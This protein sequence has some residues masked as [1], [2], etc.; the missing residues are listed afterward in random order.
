MN[1]KLRQSARGRECTLRFPGICSHDPETTVLCHV[2]T[3]GIARK[4]PDTAAVF[5]CAC[6]HDLIDRRDARWAEF[7]PGEIAAQV[8]RALVE[9]H[10]IWKREGLIDA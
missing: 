1:P 2:A 7:G 9:T 8:L 5:G 6:C 4:V 10:E 3:G